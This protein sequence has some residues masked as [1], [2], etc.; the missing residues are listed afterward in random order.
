[1]RESAAQRLVFAFLF[2]LAAGALVYFYNP[3]DHLRADLRADSSGVK[4]SLEIA[5]HAVEKA[6][7]RI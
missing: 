7:A 5:A 3:L 4:L 1:M 2:A 6:C